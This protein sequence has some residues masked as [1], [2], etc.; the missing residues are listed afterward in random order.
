[1]VQTTET[2]GMEM[3]TSPCSGQRLT[4]GLRQY[5]PELDG[6]RGLAIVAVM[7]YHLNLPGCSLGLGRRPPFLRSLRIS[8]HG[9]PPQQQRSARILFPLLCAT[10]AP[11]LPDLL[12]SSSSGSCLRD[13]SRTAVQGHAILFRLSPKLCHSTDAQ[14][15]GLSGHLH[16]HLVTGSGRAVLLIVANDCF[17]AQT[18]RAAGSLRHPR[19]LLK[20]LPLRCRC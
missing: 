11:H 15:P 3:M 18:R 19:D 13:L 5:I 14:Q 10:G 17:P 9:D 2:S 7:L 16:S 12:P 1:M 6:I 8:D 4:G 20:P